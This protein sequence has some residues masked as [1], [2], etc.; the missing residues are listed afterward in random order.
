MTNFQMNRRTMLRVLAPLPSL[1]RFRPEALPQCP[2]RPSNKLRV[3]LQGLFPIAE[4][5]FTEDDKIDLDCLANQVRFC[6]RGRVRGIAWPQIASGW[7]NLSQ[8]ERLSGAEAM[9][10]AGKGG[11]TA[12]VIGVQ[13]KGND[14]PVLCSMQNM[15][16][17]MGRTLSSP[18]ARGR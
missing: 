5:P 12:I 13:T 8:E 18:P 6:N 3:F 14:S 15:Q 2:N 16:A 7:S 1:P 4:T 9:L 17:R 10:S 11:K